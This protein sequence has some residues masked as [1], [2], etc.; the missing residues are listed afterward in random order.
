M[1][2]KKTIERMKQIENENWIKLKEINKKIEIN[3]KF[4]KGIADATIQISRKNKSNY[5]ELKKQTES[6]KE[7]IV[8]ATKALSKADS[9]ITKLI[10]AINEDRAKIKDIITVIKYICQKTNIELSEPKEKSM[11]N[12]TIQKIKEK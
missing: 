9:Q 5:K 4:T 10:E 12:H 2:Y 11:D 7:Y 8:T 6:N 1:F 3:E